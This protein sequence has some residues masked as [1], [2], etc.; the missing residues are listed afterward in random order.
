MNLTTEVL[1][2]SDFSTSLLA[3][4]Y[5]IYRSCY[6]PTQ[7]SVFEQDF[8][9]KSYAVL[10]RNA[11]R[12][13]GFS[14]V[15]RIE[16]GCGARVLYSGDTVIDPQYWGTQALPNAWLREAGRIWAEAPDRP[17]YW[18]LITKGHRTYRYLPAF[19]RAYHPS[20]DRETPPETQAF[21]DRLGREKFGDRYDPSTGT[22]RADATLPT[23]VIG[24][25]EGRRS[26]RY[27][28]FFSA[29]NPG[30]RQGDELLTLCRLAPETL[31][32]RARRMFVA[33]A[34]AA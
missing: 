16:T 31:T 33:T 9:A 1:R 11:G 3:D 26:N 21:M 7:F 10:I 12:L 30:Y 28:T 4:A 23:H 24:E 22:I 6:T 20:P 17:L 27:A 34:A 2:A 19:S 13:V 18:M 8:M 25:I 29:R 15:E 5:A 32:P 14:T